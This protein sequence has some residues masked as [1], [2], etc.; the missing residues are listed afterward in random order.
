MKTKPPA[1][2]LNRA[3]FETSRLSEFFNPSELTMQIGYGCRDWP[4]ALVKEQIDNGLDACEHAE[5]VPEI[6]VTVE[7]A[8]FSVQDNGPGLPKA[9]IQKAFDYSIR[10]SNKTY[11]VSP[12]RR[13][14][15]NA[16]KCRKV[17]PARDPHSC[18]KLP[19]HL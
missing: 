17:F 19:H 16:L 7:P 10:V 2:T 8:A 12:T 9:K 6:V 3:T 5:I 14:L 1:I 18:K 11:Y 15:G 13:R 4:S